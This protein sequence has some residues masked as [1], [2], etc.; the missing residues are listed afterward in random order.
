M[1]DI[2]AQQAESD[3]TIDEAPNREVKVVVKGK[4]VGYGATCEMMVQAGLVTLTETD[5]L[6]SS[7]GVW[8][9]GYAF[10]NTSIVERLNN[11][12]VPFQA[13]VTDIWTDPA[14]KV[15]VCAIM[16]T[17]QISQS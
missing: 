1:F 13:T 17:M 15:C 11:R 5:K 6:P 7:G 8:T 10:A 3:L 12:Q 14:E 16:E 9:P 2:F 4:N